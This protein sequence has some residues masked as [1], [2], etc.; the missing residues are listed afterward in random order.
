MPRG[1]GAN[2]GAESE[3]D[4]ETTLPF[5]HLGERSVGV[6]PTFTRGGE[7]ERSPSFFLPS[8]SSLPFALVFFDYRYFRPPV[9]PPEQIRAITDA[10]DRLLARLLP[11]EEQSAGR[12]F[13]PHTREKARKRE[14]ATREKVQRRISRAILFSFLSA[15][16]RAGIL[17]LRDSPAGG[18]IV[19]SLNRFVSKR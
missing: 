13:A 7:N 4:A 6:P 17:P 14:D 3:R 5:S 11:S 1:I 10:S 2:D 16:S 19:K 15:G 8:F 18:E 9:T 12:S